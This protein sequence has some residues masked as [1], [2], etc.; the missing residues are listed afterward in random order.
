MSP[1][2]RAAGSTAGSCRSRTPGTAAS[3]ST[4][5]GGSGVAIMTA[6]SLIVA[7]YPALGRRSRRLEQLLGMA[8]RGGVR[9]VGA[10]HPHELADD[11]AALEQRHGGARRI[12]RR[13]LDDR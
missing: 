10:E 8:P 9:V 1:V 6:R 5:S 4:S 13:V 2:K 7:A 11:G 3:C 12:G